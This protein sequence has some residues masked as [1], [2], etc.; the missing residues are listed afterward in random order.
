MYMCVCVWVR[1]E[2]ESE[3]EI[4]EIMREREMELHY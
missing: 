3:K 1:K 2:T 4:T